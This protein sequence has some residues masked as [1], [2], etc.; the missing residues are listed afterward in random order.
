MSAIL[1]IKDEY[2]TVYAFYIQ[3][4]REFSTPPPRLQGGLILQLSYNTPPA[5][6]P[7]NP[8]NMSQGVLA[9]WAVALALVSL[10]KRSCFQHLLVWHLRFYCYQCT[11]G[12]A[13][14]L[15]RTEFC[16]ISLSQCG[17]WPNSVC[18]G[19]GTYN[20]ARSRGLPSTEPWNSAIWFSGES[21]KLLTPEVRF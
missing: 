12:G 1:V 17:H 11:A 7:D 16:C 19:E 18:A 21:S 15:H 6:R 4:T 14:F 3:S 20:C 5:S 2:L 10:R 8:P 13:H 9:W